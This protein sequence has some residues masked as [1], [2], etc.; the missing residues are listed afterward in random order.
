[1]S[2]VQFDSPGLVMGRLTEIENDLAERQNLYETAAR[3]WFDAQREIKR[4][5]ATALISSQASSVTEKKAAADLAGL[6][7][8]GAE[9][10]AEYQALKSVIGV[11]ETRATICMSILKAQGRS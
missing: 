4:E 5:W 3:E 11:L 8:E 9:H 7:V 10:E 1:M 6:M 2:V